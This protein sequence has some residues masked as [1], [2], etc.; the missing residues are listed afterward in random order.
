[1]PRGGG[2][3]RVAVALEWRPS[4][5]RSPQDGGC[6]RVALASG[7]R[8]LRVVVGPRMAG[9]LRLVG[10]PGCRCRG[11]RPCPAAVVSDRISRSRDATGSG[12]RSPACASRT[13][14]RASPCDGN[15][16]EWRTLDTAR[17]F[18]VEF[19]FPARM[20]CAPL[21]PGQRTAFSSDRSARRRRSGES[22]VFAARGMTFGK[23]GIHSPL[24]SGHR[25]ALTAG[26]RK[27]RCPRRKHPTWRHGRDVCSRTS[28]T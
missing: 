4:G 13:R 10:S 27:R 15:R 22:A 28:K 16:R 12:M 18:R 17:Q 26:G 9:C 19:L 2:G 1:M 11:R 23:G 21:R 6:C 24:G 20:H 3:F 25:C 5:R 8:L 14:A 7:R